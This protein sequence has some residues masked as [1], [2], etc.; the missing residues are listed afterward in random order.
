VRKGTLKAPI[1]TV[2]GDLRAAD[3]GSAHKVGQV[4]GPCCV[5]HGQ[6]RERGG[7]QAQHG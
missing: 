5:R 4:V 6:Q 2:V 1:L 3:D 7:A